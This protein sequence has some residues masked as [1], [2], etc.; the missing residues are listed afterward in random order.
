MTEIEIV[1]LFRSRCKIMC[2][3]VSIVAVPNAGKRTRWAAMNAKREGMASGF[4]DIIALWKGPG[5]AAIEF[6]TKIGRISDNQ[7]EWLDRL[8]NMGIPATISR[9]PDHAIEFLRSHG[10]PFIGRL[11]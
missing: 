7:A 5:V 3:G 9:D 8:R 1:T 10:A 11:S 4:P 6:K 2:P